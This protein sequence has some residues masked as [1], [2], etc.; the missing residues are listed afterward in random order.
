M[1]RVSETTGKRTTRGFVR[2][3][4]ARS[5]DEEH[6]VSTPLELFFD[7]CFVV[8]VAQASN[9]LHH[10]L[11]EDD[12]HQVLVGYPIAFFAIWWAWMNFTW[13]SSAYDNDDVLYRSGVFVQII[14]VLILAA[15]VPR[16]FSGASFAIVTLGYAVMRVGLVFLWLRAARDDV[17]R[18]QTDAR[19]AVGI[20]AC[21][22]GWGLLLLLPDGIHVAGIVVMVVAEL[23]VPVWAEQSTPTSWH[24][25]HIAER[26]GL[27]TLIVLGESVAAATIAIQSAADAGGAV[28]DLLDVAAGGVLIVF[29]M[30]WMYF[31]QPVGP[32]VERA[33]GSFDQSSWRQAFL[34]GYGHYV[35]FA[36]AAAVGAGLAV[37]AD[38]AIGHADLSARGATTCVAVPTALYLLSV[39]AIHLTA[40]PAGPVRAAAPC[41]AIL[42]MV[43][44]VAGL[45]VL[46]V[47][48][49][50]VAL[51][52]FSELATRPA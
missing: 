7:L 18:R 16:A 37:A 32:L 29:A 38:Q 25:H 50:L 4:L 46:A 36:S 17:P 12:L 19:Y 22:V 1:E 34:W 47:G 2:P 13:F 28:G 20:S 52:V 45:P 11:A 15:G 26:F 51:V 6:R 21:M 10:A 23:L 39:W 30:W 48:L 41:A 8:A 5:T 44:A 9:S 49:I 24:P 42:V 3:L 14:G 31:A 27:F 35:V 43:V 33:R 40:K